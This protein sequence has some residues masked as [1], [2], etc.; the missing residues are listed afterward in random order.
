[1]FKST[2]GKG[3][4]KPG[5]ILKD[6]NRKEMDV[7]SVLFVPHTTNSNLAKEI[8]EREEDLKE[9]TG[10]RVKVVE[11]AGMKLQDILV[12]D[13]W[14]GADCGRPNCLPCT[15]KMLTEKGKRKDCSKRNL[16]YEIWCISCDEKAERKIEEMYENDHELIKEKKKEIRSFKYIGETSRSA[17]ERG[18]EHID[19]MT[20]LNSKSMLLRHKLDQH[21]DED[22]EK[23]KWG[24]KVI[25]FKRTA[26]ERQIKEA[27]LIERESKNHTILNSKSEWNMSTIPRLIAQ[28]DNQEI[29]QKEE[30]LR[31]EKAK[32]ESY[33]RKIR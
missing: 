26:F 20:S 30:E 8:R 4:P 1:M 19:K 23:I 25:E 29:W 33:E 31:K 3:R 5:K 17:Y 11:R 12:K 22:L 15:T 9:I 2:A 16:V 28:T 21:P 14:K 10:S 7:T 13:P 24:M 6:E 27:V 18:F 32:E